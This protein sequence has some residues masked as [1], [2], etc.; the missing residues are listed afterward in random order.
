MKFLSTIYSSNRSVINLYTSDNADYVFIIKKHVMT[1]S[2]LKE[3]KMLYILNHP[4]I[5]KVDDWRI[6]GSDISV[7]QKYY[8]NGDLLDAIHR[9]KNK[10]SLRII[11]SQLVNAV[12]YLHDRNIVHMDI[13]PENIMLDQDNNVTLIDFD[14]SSKI[15]DLKKK[16]KTKETNET[17]ETN[18][19]AHDIWCIGLVV[20]EMLFYTDVVSFDEIKTC[21]SESIQNILKNTL[22][23]DQDKRWNIDQLFAALTCL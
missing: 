8:E 15:C 20:Y 16:N 12:K 21:A 10:L 13:R 14:S 5:V 9:W 1:A 7:T 18:P 6:S 4:N 23:S 22:E 2:S 19:K 3:I 17:N 11:L